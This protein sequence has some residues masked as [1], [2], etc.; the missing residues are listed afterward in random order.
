[1]GL[2]VKVT[3]VPEQIALATG[4]M[5]TI[6]STFCIT[7]IVISFDATEEDDKQ[8]EDCVILTFILSPFC[9]DEL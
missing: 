1:M 2:A 8:G 9:K 6:G 4:T 7:A 5:V 3:V